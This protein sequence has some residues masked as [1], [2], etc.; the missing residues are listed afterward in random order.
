MN[1]SRKAIFVVLSIWI[2]GLVTGIVVD[3]KHQKHMAK[4]ER[5]VNAN[6]HNDGEHVFVDWD[7]VEDA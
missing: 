6:L 5:C 3:K 7:K 4:V 1:G 2:G